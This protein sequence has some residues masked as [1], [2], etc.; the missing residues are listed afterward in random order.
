MDI[1]LAD[2]DEGEQGMVSLKMVT[3]IIE[4]RVE[5]IFDKIELEL[6]KIGRSGMLPAGI[7]ITGGG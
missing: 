3:Q 2:I 5:E 1:D 4:A 6:K 7:V